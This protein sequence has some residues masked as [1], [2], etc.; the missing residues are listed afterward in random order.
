MSLSTA[1]EIVPEHA[2]VELVTLTMNPALDIAA[3]VRRVRPT[4]K[5]RC[6][7][8]IRDPGGGGIN[9][10]RV[11]AVLGCRALAVFP[12]GGLIGEM[13][14]DM[15]TIAGIRHETVAISDMTRQ[16]FTVGE[17]DTGLQYRFV[18]PGPQLRRDEEDQLLTA[19]ETV[20]AGAQIVVASGSLPPGVAPD[21][22]QRVAD[23]CQTRGW[24]LILDTSGAGLAAMRSGV[25]LLKPSVRE[26]GEWAG[27][28]LRS[29]G[30]LL[31]A[32]H[33]ILEMGCAEMVLVSR[34]P[35]GTLLCGAE[36]NYRF[37]APPVPTGS[38]VG[39][40]DALVAGVACG[41]LRG[42]TITDAVRLG[43]AA[44]AA[45]LATPGTA[46]CE[47]AEV[48]GLLPKIPGPVAVTQGHLVHTV[49]ASNQR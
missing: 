37:C 17:V 20:A 47:L 3:T 6:N 5:L 42:W 8:A 29:E 13:V 43:M 9:V 27:R 39:A 46:V 15:L 48:R 26:L 4:D 11:A 24:K 45:M 40:G 19:L 28:R 23:M 35:A 25:F 31:L 49:P 34:G 33:Q 10:A 18:M 36:F 16:N 1:P 7:K 21:F 12:T 32:A 2:P 41:L 38:G 14:S 30:D 22:Y 44:G